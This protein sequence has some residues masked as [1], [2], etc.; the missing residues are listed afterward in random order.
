MISYGLTV[1]GPTS[2]MFQ[3]DSS[4]AQITLAKEMNFDDSPYLII[5]RA[6]DGGGN[7]VSKLRDCIVK[8]FLLTCY[9]VEY[10][11]EMI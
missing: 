10:V 7:T 3:M 9:C 2:D 1:N 8:Q 6:T 11:I 4:T 5:I